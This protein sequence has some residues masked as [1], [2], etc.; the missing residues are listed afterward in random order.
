MLNVLER[1]AINQSWVVRV[2]RRVIWFWGVLGLI[3][4]LGALP[5]VLSY[6]YGLPYLENIDEVR[7]YF[8]AQSVRGLYDD[9]EY[10]RSYPPGIVKIYEF[11]QVVM[12]SLGFTGTAAAVQLV[13]LLAVA[14]NL[15]GLAVIA[16][17]GRYV[18]GDV[19]GLVAAAAWAISPAVI[20]ETVDAISESFADPLVVLAVWLAAV[21]LSDSHRW[22][23]ALV[24]IFLSSI[25]FILEYRFILIIIPGLVALVV[26][27]LREQRYSRRAWLLLTAVS[28]AGIVLIL[29]LVR[30]LHPRRQV[31]FWNSATRYLWDAET[32]LLYL[33]SALQPLVMAVW[34]GLGAV[35]FGAYLLARRNQMRVNGLALLP[36]ILMMVLLPWVVSA[37]RLYGNETTFVLLRHILPATA[38]A[39]VVLGAAAAQIIYII[40]GRALYRVAALVALA[41]LLVGPQIRPTIALVR[42]REVQSWHVIIR[43]WADVNLEPGTVIVYN[44]NRNTFNPFW[45]GI[46]GRKW[47]D[48]WPTDN[49]LEYSLEE[50]VEQRGMSYALLP[51]GDYRALQETVEGQ[52]YLSNTLL[53]RQF[54]HPP[55]RREAEGA[56]LRL[57]RMQH[58]TEVHFG[59]AIVLT[60]YDQ[61][62]DSA[63]PGDAVEFT[64]Y[65]NA[66][67]TPD[68]NYSLF[69]H[70]VPEDEYT[71][72]AQADGSPAVPERPTLS[73]DEPGE[74][75]ISPPFALTIPPDLAPGDYRV[76]IGLYNFSTG[77]RLPVAGSELGDAYL[78]TL[79]HVAP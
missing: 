49:I 54:V 20:E 4:L 78:L 6:D 3:V 52:A 77:V 16:L 79:L 60:G 63:Q 73:W 64:F 28:V 21:A 47:F 23:W 36:F 61:S 1:N 66:P 38:L 9:S 24:S 31:I 5:R 70:L 50:W 41:L 55:A 37:V 13:R 71:V 43:Q 46:Q 15:I 72:L 48:W 57:W 65:W 44:E 33:E 26:K 35:G 11:A 25:L 74:T 62:A 12:E 69:V 18:G 51:I 2:P 27:F 53:L 42:N 45:G 29:I 67:A 76:L 32:V 58:E 14:A 8:M 40:P 19:A 39:C 30:N 10:A 7:I 68:D 34:L 59:D 56:F 75:L 17:A 22:Y